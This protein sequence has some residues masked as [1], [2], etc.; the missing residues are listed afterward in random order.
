MSIP[1]I[2][3]SRNRLMVLYM[4]DQGHKASLEDL[5]KT[6][7][8]VKSTAPLSFN[9]RQYVSLGLLRAELK[10]RGIEKVELV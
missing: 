7:I 6:Y 4:R 5:I 1:G 3:L 2:N 9:P 10:R 8:H